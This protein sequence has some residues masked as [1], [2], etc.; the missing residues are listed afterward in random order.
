MRANAYKKATKALEDFPDKITTANI[1][2]VGKLPGECL[3]LPVPL[4]KLDWRTRLPQPRGAV[5]T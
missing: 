3:A 2:E 5:R 1:K 4:S